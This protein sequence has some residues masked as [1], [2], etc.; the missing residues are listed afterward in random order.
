VVRQWRSS[1]WSRDKHKHNKGSSPRVI[2]HVVIIR[3]I[4]DVVV[5]KL[6][7]LAVIINLNVVVTPSGCT[8]R[9]PTITIAN[10]LGLLASAINRRLTPTAGVATA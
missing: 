5:I 1:C 9:T 2:A 6:N 8:P 7:A 3:P 4:S 10:L